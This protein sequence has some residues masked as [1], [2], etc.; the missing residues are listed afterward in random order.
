MINLRRSVFLKLA[1]SFL[2]FYSAYAALFFLYDCFANF[3]DYKKARTMQVLNH[4]R[5]GQGMM[6]TGHFE[7]LAIRLKDSHIDSYID[8]YSL[9]RGGR[10]ISGRG[11][12]GIS[13]ETILNMPADE[14]V[15]YKDSQL[16][17]IV[18][19]DA[20]L[21]VGNGFGVANRIERMWVENRKSVLQ[22]VA[23]VLV[24]LT[25]MTLYYFKDLIQVFRSIRKKDRGGI[26]AI[27]TGSVES[28]ILV[29]ALGGYEHHLRESQEKNKLLSEQLLPALRN[30]LDSGRAP[31][32]E[33]E[34]AMVRTDI[35]SFSTIFN[36]HPH[37]PFMATISEFFWAATHVLSRY[38]GLVHEFA[39]DEVIYYFK[40]EGNA[41]RLAASA[42]RDIHDLA[43]G[44]HA[45]VRTERGYDFIVK[46]SIATGTVR[47]G[48]LVHNFSLAGAPFIET[49]RILSAVQEKEKNTLLFGR[50]VNEALNGFCSTKAEGR[51][52]LKGYKEEMEL[53][54][55]V[56]HGD[57]RQAINAAK[58]GNPE[59]L[60]YFR[61]DSH[62]ESIL[63]ALGE[64][65]WSL[66]AFLAVIGVL[67]SYVCTN[68][69]KGV[70]SAYAALLEKEIAGDSHYR[71]AALVALSTQL[72]N[73][74]L[75]DKR[76]E[77]ALLS[78]LGRNDRRVTA[79]VI[80]VF[81]WFFPD[82]QVPELRRFLKDVD[83][84]I[85]ANALVKAALERFDDK[86]IRKIQE[87]VNS[88]SVAH[89]ASALYAIGEIAAYYGE[90]D[91]IYLN[92]K[93]R[94]LRL[95]DRLPDFA[96]HPNPMVR[97]Q[98]ITAAFKH[99]DDRLNRRMRELFESTEDKE[100]EELF[101]GI[102]G[103]R[104]GPLAKA[105]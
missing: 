102:Y 63:T 17:K 89:V 7:E 53:F 103:W 80:E 13:E 83:N 101:G 46:S 8:F 9:R 59:E 90:N 37:E 67:R 73:A 26:Q 70:G 49:V 61:A 19:G 3:E 99:R 68:A 93:L 44:F 82:R 64:E 74:E 95:L 10:E 48:K 1:V 22:D 27:R 35:N 38:G 52:A 2:M 79:N 57:F 54:S 69:G 32:Y 92:T 36:S 12:Q 4:L 20:T 15:R 18:V 21:V 6:K 85:S 97:R 75:F 66:E 62:I 5:I 47:F 96:R 45:R 14:L 94:F 24:C 98:A 39:G 29:R 43:A 88:G 30:E 51:A 72:L 28:E 84:R 42:V 60:A 50:A 34:C 100:L 87:R 41:S 56:S 65:G 105:A 71:V 33:F 77:A 16:G 104:R 58:A 76:L 40:D 25:L 78:A 81:S 23:F 31:P 86:V 91:P 55:Y 11:G